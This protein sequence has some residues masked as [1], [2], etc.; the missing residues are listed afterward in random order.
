MCLIMFKYS[1]LNPSKYNQHGQ[2]GFKYKIG[3]GTGESFAKLFKTVHKGNVKG[4]PPSQRRLLREA[5]KLKVSKN[6]RTR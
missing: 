2:V 6:S 3:N 1:L 4:C 5:D